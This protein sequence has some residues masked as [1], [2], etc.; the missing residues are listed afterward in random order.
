VSSIVA[1]VVVV[2]VAVVATDNE[3]VSGV[4]WLSGC[5]IPSWPCNRSE[6]Q[7]P[8]TEAFPNSNI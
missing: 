8:A 6:P 5:I 1:V 4:G 3:W 2:V 7:D